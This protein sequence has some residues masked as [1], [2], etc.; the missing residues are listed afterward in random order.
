MNTSLG[1]YI[2]KVIYRAQLRQNEKKFWDELQMLT[3]FHITIVNIS[4]TSSEYT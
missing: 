1:H 2:Y 3:L 4:V